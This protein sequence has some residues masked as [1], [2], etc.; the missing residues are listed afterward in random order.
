MSK[1]LQEA[2]RRLGPQPIGREEHH[3]GSKDTKEDTKK[4]GRKKA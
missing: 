1:T 3:Q 4:M 2:Q